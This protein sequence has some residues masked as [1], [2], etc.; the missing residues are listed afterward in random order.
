MLKGALILAVIGLIV[1]AAPPRWVEAGPA[2]DCE[3]RN[4][5][6]G[7]QWRRATTTIATWNGPCVDG[8]AHGRG[9]LEWFRDGV[10]FVH[11]EGE[12]SAGRMIGHGVMMTPQGIRYDGT[13][14]DGVFERGIGIYPDG[15][16]FE[17]NGTRVVGAKAS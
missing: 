9:V 3:V 15:R 8:R 1:A 17:A 10:V 11:Y 5:Y 16:R 2:P 13:W 4:P 14:D 7:K 12:M 6:G